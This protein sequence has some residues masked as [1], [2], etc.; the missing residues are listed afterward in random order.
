MYGYIV[1][2][3]SGSAS[4]PHLMPLFIKV[5]DGGLHGCVLWRGVMSI[6]GVESGV[7]VV[8][9]HFKRSCGYS[10]AQLG[11]IGGRICGS[12]IQ[13]EKGGASPYHLL[14]YEI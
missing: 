7:P 11:I 8:P 9:N 2:V 13:V 14:L 6:F 12:S 3:R 10:G 1:G 4:S 5:D